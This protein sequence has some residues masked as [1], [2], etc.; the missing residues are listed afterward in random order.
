MKLIKTFLT[1]ILLVCLAILFI[2]EFSFAQKNTWDTKKSSNDS[3]LLANSEFGSSANWIGP[4]TVGN[5]TVNCEYDF[6]YLLEAPQDGT[7]PCLRLLQSTILG[8]A[9]SAI[10][11][12]VT[13]EGGETY[14]FDAAVKEPAK[15]DNPATNF[16]CEF[17]LTKTLP[18]NLGPDITVA[19]GAIAMGYI[20]YKGWASSY[21]TYYNG[22]LS[23]LPAP[24]S[25]APFT[26]PGTGNQTYYFV[27]KSGTNSGNMEVFVD[28]LILKKASATDVRK[29]NSIIPNT[30]SLE[31]NYPNPF[32][33][34]TTIKFS[35]P[36]ESYVSL[37]V[38]NV[39]GEEVAAMV[40]EQMSPGYYN[41][42][43]DAS[44]LTSGMYL[45]RLNAGDFVS[46]KKMILIK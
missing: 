42:S 9:N 3:N 12:E 31:Q 43:F 11:Q 20:K 46:T 18:T 38:Y 33:P 6:N 16:W 10:Y 28:N 1:R 23:G 8:N 39:I 2:T 22:L 21:I 15:E 37:K 7:A 44:K 29:E 30:F 32:N 40:S 36:K 17:Y 19:N 5:Y 13:L 35:I 45:Y 14:S 34:S 26:V 27:I 24:L 41:F 4:L 25:A